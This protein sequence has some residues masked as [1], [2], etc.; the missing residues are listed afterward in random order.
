MSVTSIKPNLDEEVKTERKRQEEASKAALARL[1]DKVPA[2][3][4]VDH[5]LAARL[6]H[7]EQEKYTGRKNLKS[8]HNFQDIDDLVDE[9]VIVKD[10]GSGGKRGS[11]TETVS[12]AR[13]DISAARQ[14][15]STVTPKNPPTTT[16]LFDDEDVT[17]A[18]TL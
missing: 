18:D 7:K 6:T 1:Y 2:Q 9:E 3:I 8:Q 4:D 16:T 14:E 10:K 11:T 5:E 12:A 15:V 17:S 13:P